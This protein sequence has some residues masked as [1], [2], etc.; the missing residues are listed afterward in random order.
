MQK[1]LFRRM[2]RSIYAD[3]AISED[4]I[5]ASGLD[6]TTVYPT[7]LTN[8]PAQGAYRAGDRLP[9]KGLPLIS[10]A[11]VAFMLDAARGS[12]WVRRDAVS[13]TEATLLDLPNTPGRKGRRAA[14]S[15]VTSGKRPQNPRK[16]GTRPSSGDAAKCPAN[17]AYSATRAA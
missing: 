3:K 4:L 9:T 11:D 13:P 10:R 2:L 15:A 16:L 8:G 12:E 14:P 1:L 5:R 17:R 7:K 6:W